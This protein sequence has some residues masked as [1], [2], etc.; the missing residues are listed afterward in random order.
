VYRA[1]HDTTADASF[2]Q[3]RFLDGLIDNRDPKD[4]LEGSLAFWGSCQ[5]MGTAL[6][7][8]G[9]TAV[10]TISERS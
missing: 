10:P 5:S 7:T 4:E 1:K 9:A 6:T 2:F 3:G 8:P